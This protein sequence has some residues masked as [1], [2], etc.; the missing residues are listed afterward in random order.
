MTAEGTVGALTCSLN[1]NFVQSDQLSELESR[2]RSDRKKEGDFPFSCSFSR[3][4]LTLAVAA[5]QPVRVSKLITS[6]FWMTAINF[7]YDLLSANPSCSS[8]GACFWSSNSERALGENDTDLIPRLGKMLLRE[9][10]CHWRHLVCLLDY[11]AM[12]ARYCCKARQLL[13]LRWE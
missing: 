12:Y 8:Q 4:Q 11:T 9:W 3:H 13:T 7:L 1:L 10:T 5:S 2:T 6:G